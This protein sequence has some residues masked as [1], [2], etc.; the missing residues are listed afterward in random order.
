MFGRKTCPNGPP[1]IDACQGTTAAA[2]QMFAFMNI[3]TVT[4]KLIG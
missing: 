1:I 3:S 4:V 2:M